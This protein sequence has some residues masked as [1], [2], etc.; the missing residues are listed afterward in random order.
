V[1]E[2]TAEPEHS[3]EESE[4]LALEGRQRERDAFDDFLAQ[5]SDASPRPEDNHTSEGGSSEATQ[6]AL[7]LQ[8][9][10][11]TQLPYLSLTPETKY[12]SGTAEGGANLD[13][14]R[15]RKP[16]D[17]QSPTPFGGNYREE[18]PEETFVSAASQ[19]TS[20]GETTTGRRSAT[21]DTPIPHA[22][23]ESSYSFRDRRKS[24]PYTEGDG[25]APRGERRRFARS[26]SDGF[27]LQLDLTGDYR[28]TARTMDLEKIDRTRS[29]T[30][31]RE[32][33]LRESFRNPSRGRDEGIKGHAAAA[34]LAGM[35]APR[36]SDTLQ[37]SQERVAA[38]WFALKGLMTANVEPALDAVPQ[39]RSSKETGA[40]TLS[41][42][43][44]AGGVGKTSLVATLG[45]VLSS[46]GEKVLLAETSAYGLLPYYF[47][48]RE[49]RA[50]VVRT[51]SPHDGSTNAP[52]YLVNYQ[53]EL[54]TSDEAGQAR[55][56]EDIGRHGTGTQRILLDL[57]GSSAW[58]ARQLSQ[59]NSHILVPILPDMN[60]VLGIKGVERFFA[61]AQDSE[62]RAV[63]PYYVL[64][65]FDASLPLH[66]D[67]R[68]V[69]R[70]QLGNRLLPVTIRRSHAVSESLAEGMTVADYA[71]GSPVAEDYSHLAEWVRNLAAPASIGLRR[72]RWSERSAISTDSAH[73]S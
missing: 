49:L 40:P 26:A 36:V 24:G 71:P 9:A 41:V 37:Q 60:S 25:S 54:L 47:G 68:E 46:L 70:K 31:R 18:T 42:V 34:M 58:L 23:L 8:A 10:V 21:S 12:S 4:I 61:G 3:P 64:N 38:R 62:G 45:R 6:G 59:A 56:V 14:R 29:Q 57:N 16:L 28:L 55:L 7:T 50:N 22:T 32:V 51:F 33:E 72:S 15:E 63:T 69:L 1:E 43:S 13:S 44:L 20:A 65:Q 30:A 53:T 39:T 48:A 11:E 19:V 5:S 27:E 2:T 73:G 66:L 52:L 17:M 67:V 35:P